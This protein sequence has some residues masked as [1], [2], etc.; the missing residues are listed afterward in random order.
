MNVHVPQD[1][2]AIAE[3]MVLSTTK[4]KMFSPQASKS[5]LSIIQDSLLGAWLMTRHDDK[6]PESDFFNICMKGEGWSSPYILKKVQHI[7]RVLK[8]CGK[9]VLAYNG[10]GLVSMMLP[11]DFNYEKTNK[12]NPDQPTV[13]IYRGV[14]IEGTLNKALL[15]ASHN[16][17]I[18]CLYK[19]YNVDVAMTF[20]NNIQYIT[21]AYLLYHGFSLG[22]R[23]CLPRNTN[24][25]QESIAKGFVEA[26]SIAESTHHPKIKEAKINSTLSN[27]KNVGMKIATD[28]MTPDNSFVATVTSG[29]RGDYFNIAQITG[30]LGQQ[31]LT[32]QRFIPMIN[33]GKRT[34]PH[35]KYEIAD[36][37]KDFESRGFIKNSLMKGLNPRE[38][39]FHAMSGREGVSDTAMKTSSSGYVQRKM[40]KVLEDVSVKYDGTVRNSIGNIIQW[41]YAEDGLDRAST[42][43]LKDKAEVCD[44]SRLAERLNLR[45]ETKK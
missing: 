25:I 23:D 21:N 14:M 18:Q 7:R 2:D 8:A 44:V 31:C 32:G 33:R 5:N 19:E 40:I 12:A 45:H 37:E 9:K 4:A 13:K 16:S 15:G 17:L 38:F 22:I 43:V 26:K 6:I 3:M 28:A 29:S 35:Y 24:M 20:V 27:T 10:K 39:W 30:T 11:D 41:S 1:Y 36:V 42:V 34:L